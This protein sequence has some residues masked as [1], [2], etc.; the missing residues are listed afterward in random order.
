MAN[1]IHT[2]GLHIL[3]DRDELR[4]SIGVCP[5]FDVLYDDL[6]CSAQVML[7]AKIAGLP[8]EARGSRCLTTSIIP[9]VHGGGTRN[10]DVNMLRI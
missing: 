2:Q 10:Q 4:R 5:Q 7:F 9:P 1:A 3:E 8:Y 6:T